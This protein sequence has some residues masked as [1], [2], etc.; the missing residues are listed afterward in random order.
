ML[1]ISLNAPGKRKTSARGKQFVVN[2][3]APMVNYVVVK[4]KTVQRKNMT[5]EL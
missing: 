4:N 5:K 2:V 1:A 3:F